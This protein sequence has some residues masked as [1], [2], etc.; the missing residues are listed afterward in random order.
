MDSKKLTP[1]EEIEKCIKEK[2][3]FVLQGGAGSGKTETLKQTLGFISQKYPDKKAACI[4][5][6][7]LAA[8]EIASRVGKSYTISTIHSFLN[9]L[10]KDFKINIHQVV[11]EIFKLNKVERKELSF[12]DGDERL[13]KKEEHKNYKKLYE[14]YGKQLFKIKKESIGKV[15]G[16]PEYDK[17]PVS[18]NDKLNTKIENL[19]LE[20]EGIIAKTDYKDK[21]KVKYNETKFDS[22][23]NLT[24]GHDSLLTISHLLFGKYDLLGKILNDKFDFIFIDEYQDTNE[25][26]IDVFLN[27][28]PNTNKTIVGFFGDSMQGIYDDGIGDV[29]SYISSGQLIKIEKED[30]FRCSEQVIS[31]INQFRNDDLK[32]IVALKKD[33]TI[34]HRQG[35]GKLY[36][37][38][39]NDKKPNSHSNS[40]DKEKYLSI[41]NSL[42]KEVEKENKGFKKL[43]LTNKSISI[44]V[45]FRE[46]YRIFD[47]RY[48]DVKDEI[49]KVLSRIQMIDLAELFCAYKN[50]RYNF[51]IS[52]LK[53]AGFVIKSITDKARIK[54]C[55]EKI[56]KPDCSAIEAIEI[57]FENKLIKK[58][59]AFSNYENRKDER[60]KEFKNNKEYQ[61]FKKLFNEGHN[62]FSKMSK[63]KS[64]F[65]KEKFEE[66]EYLLKEEN[67]YTDIFSEK[68]SFS[69]VINYY[70]Y[71]TELEE[72][73]EE[74]EKI[75]FMTMHKTK[76]SSIENVIVVLDEYFWSKYD[77]KTI[78][79]NETS[80]KKYD[81]TLKLFYV[82]CSRA[83][84]NLINVR[85]IPNEEEEII[86][87]YFTESKKIELE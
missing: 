46:L 67:F 77:F 20:I 62:T 34:E 1:R 59:E 32:Q 25:Q 56:L 45:G 64:D 6:T 54:E 14:K 60:L 31:F 44:E 48:L 70:K 68:L 10:I 81:K 69:E 42:I 74:K 21:N 55:F 33:E 50:N 13:Q 7:N 49:E 16:K 76:G 85:L 65:H 87:K 47:D 19:N 2:Q 4:T 41:L 23:K 38:I 75:E 66:L 83:K 15:V 30:N 5:H 27:S 78:F 86:K 17:K 37:S 8:A 43:M 73:I 12:Y 51:V 52:E 28:I 61:G 82:A 35:F 63:E 36:Y 9:D 3:N 18:F 26:I 39:Y 40:D 24:F 11:F 72:N 84:S 79:N 53:N 22:L 71:I 58:S 80:D 29:N 57:A